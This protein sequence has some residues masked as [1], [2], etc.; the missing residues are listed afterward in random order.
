ME[1]REILAPTDPLLPAVRGLY[2]RALDPEERIPD[3]PL[4]LFLNPCGGVAF[5]GERTRAAV[6]GLL[7]RI[8]RVAPGDAVYDRTLTPGCQ[9]E[10][11]PALSC[12]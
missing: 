4:E 12:R 10:L 11:A 8:Y 5:D 1:F 7:R 3:V 2:E 9:P 6:D